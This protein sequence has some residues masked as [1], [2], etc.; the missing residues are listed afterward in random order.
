M[1]SSS[2]TNDSETY[3]EHIKFIKETYK[4]QDLTDEIYDQASKYGEA[5]V[6]IVPYKKAVARLLKQKNNTRAELDIKEH[7]IITESGNIEMDKLPKEI[8]PEMFEQAGLNNIQ[9][10]C[11]T[12]AINSVVENIMRFEKHLVH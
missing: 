12:G 4:F 5:F 8:T 6:Y 1:T 9:L 10:E 2:I 7:T 3:N 11:Y